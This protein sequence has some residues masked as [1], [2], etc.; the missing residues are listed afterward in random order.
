MNLQIVKFAISQQQLEIEYCDTKVVYKATHV[1]Q[2][3]GLLQSFQSKLDKICKCD[4][5]LRLT[6]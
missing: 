5:I 6:K 3:V 2:I 4:S 1:R